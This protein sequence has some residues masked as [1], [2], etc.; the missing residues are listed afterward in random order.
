MR[1]FKKLLKL[2]LPPVLVK[3]PEKLRNRAPEDKELNWSGPFEDWSMA[4]LNSKGYDHPAILEKCKNASLK[5]KNGEAIYERDSVLFDKKQYS[6]PLLATLQKAA[7]END[8][9]L[10]VLDFGGSLGSSYFQNRDFFSTL[11]SLQWCIVEQ[12]DFVSC[13]KTHFEDGELKFYPTIESGLAEQQPNVLLLSGVLQCLEKPACWMEKFVALKIPYIVI[14]RTCFARTEHDVLMIQ[15]VSEKI[16]ASSY[17]TWFFNKKNFLSHFNGYQN[18]ASFESY[19][20]GDTIL[21][22]DIPAWWEGFILKRVD[23]GGG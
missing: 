6:F 19:C 2:F 5:V 11:K 14:D 16:Y 9:R 21:P 13:G 20:D 17:P 3:L 22:G 1:K 8:G 10:C 23:E 4:L 15:Q 12:P 18:L 7:I